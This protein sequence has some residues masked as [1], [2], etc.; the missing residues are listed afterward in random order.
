MSRVGSLDF[1]DLKVNGSPVGNF[2]L[3][4]MYIA[5]ETFPDEFNKAQ[6]ESA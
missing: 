6:W 1:L 2:E 5:A 4:P 3:S